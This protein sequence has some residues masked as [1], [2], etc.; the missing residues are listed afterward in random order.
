M[1]WVKVVYAQLVEILFDRLYICMH[2]L[3]QKK[4]KDVIVVN[5]IAFMAFLQEDYSIIKDSSADLG[6]NF[7]IVQNRPKNF[8]LYLSIFLYF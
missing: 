6:V 4:F 1:R 7:K 5:L 8:F 2:L 3:L